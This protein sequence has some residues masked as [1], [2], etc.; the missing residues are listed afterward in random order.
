MAQMHADGLTGPTASSAPS[1]VCAGCAVATTAP[2]LLSAVRGQR[3]CPPCLGRR[4]ARDARRLRRIVLLGGLF[5][6]LLLGRAPAQGYLFLNLAVLLPLASFASL[7][8][9]ELGHAL[10]ARLLGFRVY[11]L[12]LGAGPSSLGMRL[13]GVDLMLRGLPVGGF[14]EAG[15]R[16]PRA[17][18]ARVALFIAAGP[19][20]NLLVL[21]WLAPHGA[22][23]LMARLTGGL[24]P[25][26]LLLAT[27]A[28]SVVLSL[29]PCGWPR[30]ADGPTLLAA[31]RGGDAWRAERLA[32]G[33]YLAALDAYCNQPLN[34]ASAA[35]ADALAAYPTDPRLRRLEGEMAM[36]RQDWPTAIS[37]FA[38]LLDSAEPGEAHWWDALCLAR[39]HAYAQ[40]DLALAESL[41]AAAVAAM[42]WEPLAV[43][44]RGVVLVAAG[45]DA[46][47]ADL[48]DQAA[49]SGLSPVWQAE[50]GVWQA[51]ALARLGRE[52]EAQGVLARVH[53]ETGT[54]T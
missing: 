25:E 27:N 26:P 51:K 2:D 12:T 45:R 22:A 36:A 20:A 42:P 7:A 34:A 38:D 19:L 33:W 24:A 40:A 47:G 53:V 16:S 49:G 4:Q 3:L 30:R 31:L 11:S 6:L 44:T 54:A 8:L 43:G 23:G 28:L 32:A 9:H 39:C 10:A 48:L 29:L 17:L 21:A 41:T 37:R 46:E 14:T 13:G 5:G 18:R 50:F 15:T 35:L 52:A 1:A